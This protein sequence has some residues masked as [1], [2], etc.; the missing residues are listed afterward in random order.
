[1]KYV[2][3]IIT[4]AILAATLLLFC[5]DNPDRPEPADGIEG[6]WRWLRSCDRYA[7]DCIYADS[8]EYYK[9]LFIDHHLNIMESYDDSTVFS[10]KY[11]LRDSI[12]A[13]NDT[14][15][16]IIINDYPSFP[17]QFGWIIDYVGQDSML[18]IEICQDCYTNKYI[19][20][21]PI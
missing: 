16:M 1:M 20:L 13:G 6:N 19:R 4:S 18:L 2:E 10:G 5:R 15:A 9:M 14:L 7:N 12:T 21:G 8:V 17:G 11:S 3:I